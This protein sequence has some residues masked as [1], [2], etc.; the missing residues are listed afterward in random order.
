MSGP[1][2]AIG[3]AAAPAILTVVI[4]LLL[5]TGGAGANHAHADP[6]PHVPGNS[7][8]NPT[9]VPPWA[10]QA[11]IDAATTCP[12]L[13]AP[14]LAAQIETE[15]NWNPDA[16]NT[17]SHATGLAQF[18]PATWATWGQDANHDGHTDPRNPT[19]AIASQAAYL[20]H[21]IDLVTQTRNLSGELIDLA[22]ASYNAGP[23]RVQQYHGIPPYP[24]TINYITKIR[25]LANTKY[26]TPP[27]AANGTTKPAD[28]VI[29]KATEHVGKTPYAWGGGTLNGPSEGTG[30]DT[31]IIGFDCS[32][33]VRYAYHQGTNYHITLPRTAQDQYNATKSQPIAIADLQSGDL[34]F[35]GHDQIHHVALYTGNG[36][37]I[38]AP[39]SGQKITETTIRT[40]GDYAGA[41]RIFGGPLDR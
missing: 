2:T 37:M 34:L 30:I 41:T 9:A 23:G 16:Y 33:L 40:T 21:L 14:L 39:Q 13:T 22:L 8:L 6:T 29:E 24:E 15:S 27:P 4:I 18:L 28:A 12:E 31:G 17:E 5:I 1:K 3:L 25:H 26:A 38:E 35:W 11:L 10:R 32:G 19:D 7:T 20:C 36:Q